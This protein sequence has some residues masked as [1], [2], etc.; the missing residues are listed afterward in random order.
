MAAKKKAAKKKVA[1][2]KT[3]KK[4]KK[5]FKTLLNLTSAK[6]V[7]GLPWLKRFLQLYN[8]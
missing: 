8:A 7:L 1:A 5:Q 4:K 2:K 6:I 3:T